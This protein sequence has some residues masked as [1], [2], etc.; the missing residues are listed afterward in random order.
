MS[1]S[2]EITGVKE[3]IRALR[4]IDPEMRKTF[5][6]NVKTIAA[7]MTDAIKAT[8]SDSM[9]PSGTKYKW[10]QGGR[11]IFPLAVGKAQRGT[12]VKID[13]NRRSTTAITVMQTNVAAAVF[14]KAGGSNKL[15][16]AL[17]AKSGRNASRVMWPVAENHIEDVRKNLLEL[18]EDLEKTIS[19]ELEK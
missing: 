1:A 18:I 16:R 11:Q 5:N 7:P 19:E 3:A 10:S 6:A 9:F 8:Y 4:K 14:D 12:K 13:T 15:G 17:S 2:H